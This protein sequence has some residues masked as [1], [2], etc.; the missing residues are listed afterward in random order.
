MASKSLRQATTG[1]ERAT[2]HEGFLRYQ[3]YKWLKI[4]L[5]MSGIA[6]LIYAFDDVQPR[7]NGGSLYGYTTGTIG[8]LLILWLTMLGVRKRAI[9]PGRWSLKSWTSAHVYLGLSL[10][11]IATL[12]TGFD[13]GWNVHTLAYVLM[14]LVIA[15]GIFGIAAYASLP[16]AL[17]AN[18]GETTQIQMLDNLR[19]L[20]RQL[21]EAAQPL[22]AE[23]AAIVQMALDDNPFGGGLIARLTGRYRQCGT[24][25]ALTAVRAHPSRQEAAADPLDHVEVLLERKRSSL[26]RI[27]KHLRLKAL[28]EIWLH[29]HIPLTFALIAALFVHIVAVFYYW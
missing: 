3:N 6:L 13:F 18:R 9:T 25:A 11:V 19:M 17:S 16:Q 14:M 24:R 10:V 22:D 23:G 1:R 7:P 26:A 15:S 8:V 29:I 27:R 5:A 2:E 21:N 12:H 20:D 4:A 28:L